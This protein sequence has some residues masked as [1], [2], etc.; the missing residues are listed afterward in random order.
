MIHLYLNMMMI[1]FKVEDVDVLWTILHVTED[2]VTNILSKHNSPGPLYF[3]FLNC[4][5][6]KRFGKSSLVLVC[7]L[8]GFDFCVHLHLL[9]LDRIE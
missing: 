9:R 2:T 1:F 7:L 8:L 4:V 5:I 3:S 6:Q